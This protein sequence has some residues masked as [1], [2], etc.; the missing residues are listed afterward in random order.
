MES[1]VNGAACRGVAPATIEEIAMKTRRFLVAKLLSQR[2]EARVL[3]APTGFG[4]SCLAAQYASLVFSFWHVFWFDCQD[5][6]FLRALSDDSL[7]RLIFQRDDQAALVVFDDV[8]A[9]SPAQAASLAKCVGNLQA[10]HCE[11]LACST[12][13]CAESFLERGAWNVVA[14]HKALL[15][16]SSEQDFAT[17][18]AQ[19]PSCGSD[20]SMA[21]IPA[22]AWGNDEGRFLLLRGFAFD[23]L[24]TE[25]VLAGLFLFA[26]Q[27]VP[28]CAFEAVSVDVKAS[29]ERLAV[30][31]P[32]FAYRRETDRYEALECDDTLFERVLLPLV[33][34]TS[35]FLDEGEARQY[36]RC[37]AALLV[38]S[39][40][41][42]RACMA[43]SVLLDRADKERFV[44]D[45]ALFF[46]LSSC[47]RDYLRLAE[48]V[49]RGHAADK[50]LLAANIAFARV[51]EGESVDIKPLWEKCACERLSLDVRCLYAALAL[52]VSAR[53]RMDAEDECLEFWRTK[54]RLDD[55][56]AQISEAHMREAHPAVARSGSCEAVTDCSDAADA[57]SAVGAAGAAGAA[58]GA[59]GA[60][61]AAAGAVGAVGAVVGA[62]GAVA[63]AVGAVGAVGVAGAAG[64]V[65]SAAGAAADTV[66]AVDTTTFAGNPLAEDATA[67]E[68]VA[69]KVDLVSNRENASFPS[70]LSWEENLFLFAYG[71]AYSHESRSEAELFDEEEAQTRSA[72]SAGMNV[73]CENT[74]ATLLRALRESV[75]WL[76]NSSAPSAPHD[77]LLPFAALIWPE[78]ASAF[79]SVYAQGQANEAYRQALSTFVAALWAVQD[80]PARFTVSQKRAYREMF[81]QMLDASIPDALHEKIER[82]LR[83]LKDASEKRKSGAWEYHAVPIPRLRVSLWG[84][85]CVSV[86]ERMMDS[87][88][89]KRKKSMVLLAILASEAGK[90]FSRDYLAEALW[91][92]S[93]LGCA[94]RNLYAVWGELRAVLRLDDGSCPYLVRAGSSYR[95]ERALAECDVSEMQDLCRCLCDETCA[96]EQWSAA[97][98]ELSARFSGDL[99]P[100]SPENEH[101]ARYGVAMKEQ[102]NNALMTAARML[103]NRGEISLALHYAKEVI[104]RAPAR[105]DACE[106]AMEAQLR[107]GQSVS[108]LNTFFG[109]QRYLADQLGV[110]PS[111]S[112]YALYERALGVSR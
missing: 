3:V 82:A 106:L 24:P 87:R 52:H 41:L 88:N 99:L 43:A 102:A 45:Q 7:D 89:F 105:E 9:L 72:E 6:R 96:Q 65:A 1:Y 42:R 44:S 81:K 35:S 25:D 40:N 107:L 97:L 55:L 90:S 48:T 64:A 77:A 22:I 19:N 12:P 68:G 20:A 67:S 56:Y 108:A 84:S 17:L 26:A 37:F 66:G 11:V 18:Y 49:E 85:F 110:D 103:F 29:F 75:A 13:V 27:S 91:P 59:V 92:R 76:E 51:F 79:P 69:R 21:R 30:R 28:G 36:A 63:G 112:V 33:A 80:A 104:K 34:E 61:G 15:V 16:Q 23:E 83:S 98:Q 60:V 94:R 54:A 8:P 95:L 50:D 53:T 73:A 70:D 2:T 57:T 38:A 32:Y 46:A 62:V 111:P 10:R 58:A 100:G 86:G 71:F 47:S 4:K 31:Y 39:G 109:C 5:L 78:D 74:C 101:L 93:P 14:Q